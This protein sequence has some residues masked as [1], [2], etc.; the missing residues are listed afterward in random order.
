[1]CQR[2]FLLWQ[3]YKSLFDLSRNQSLQVQVYSVSNTADL[4]KEQAE[5]VMRQT[6]YVVVLAT[7][8][9][10]WAFTTNSNGNDERLVVHLIL[11]QPLLREQGIRVMASNPAPA[12]VGAHT[13]VPHLGVNNPPGPGGQLVVILGNS[14]ADSTEGSLQTVSASA[15]RSP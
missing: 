8:L 6:S 11:Q 4:W 13:A 3:T 10:L 1:L 9:N 5:L 2:V 15:L 12:A 7:M 14:D